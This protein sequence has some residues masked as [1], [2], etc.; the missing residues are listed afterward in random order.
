MN[1]KLLLSAAAFSLVGSL[2]ATAC[3]ITEGDVDGFGGEG[4]GGGKPASE[5]EKPTPNVGGAGGQAG[6]GTTTLDCQTGSQVQG[7]AYA[8]DGGFDSSACGLCLDQKC[9]DKGWSACN[10]LKPDASCRYGSTMLNGS[11]VEGEFDCMLLCL[12]TDYV[13]DQE[14]VD[15]CAEQCGASECGDAL[16]KVAQDT[17]E[18][19]V[20]LTS[21]DAN[22]DP[23]L[24]GC[25]AECGLL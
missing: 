15:A 22:G 24:A 20:G 6:T 13:G 16:G 21:T 25:A 14:Q 9:C 2:I 3:T 4:G 10:A 17:A 23:D 8:C 7:S 1:R 11:A 19:L 18:C 12:A 5:V